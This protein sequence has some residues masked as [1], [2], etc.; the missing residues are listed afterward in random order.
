M[1][2]LA[3]PVRGVVVVSLGTR[4]DA[5]AFFPHVDKTQSTA[6]AAVLPAPDALAATRVTPLTHP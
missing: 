4:G 5:T 1:A 3:G 2:G 6:Q